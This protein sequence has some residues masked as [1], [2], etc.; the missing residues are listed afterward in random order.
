M[1]TLKLYLSLNIFLLIP[2]NMLNWIERYLYM[3]NLFLDVI[4][5]QRTENWDVFPSPSFKEI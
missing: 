2:G 5:F 1:S 3:V 4:R